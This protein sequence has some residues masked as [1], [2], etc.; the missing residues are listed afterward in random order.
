MLCYFHLL[1]GKTWE[2]YLSHNIC[3]G[4]LWVIVLNIPPFLENINSLII[5]QTFRMYLVCENYILNV[6]SMIIPTS[7][8]F[9]FNLYLYLSL[10]SPTFGEIMCVLTLLCVDYELYVCTISHISCYY[11]SLIVQIMDNRCGL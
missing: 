7:L 2:N 5:N 11:W 8:P 6:N 3:V 1:C 4:L 10:I 9:L